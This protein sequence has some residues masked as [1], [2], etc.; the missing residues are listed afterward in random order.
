MRHVRVVRK[1][2]VELASDGRVLDVLREGELFGH[3]SMLSGLTTGFEAR[4]GED[5][6]CYRLPADAVV[7]LL[8]RPSGLRYVARS[9]LLASAAGP[10]GSGCGARPRRPAR[11]PPGSRAPRDLRAGL[12]RARHRASHGGGGGKRRTR[13]TGRWAARHRHRPRPAR[14][15]R[16]R[17]RRERR[18]RQ[19]GDE[20]PGIH[21]DARALRRRRHARDARPRS[22]P[23]ARGLAARRGDGSAHRSRSPGGRSARALLAAANDRGGGR[24]RRAARERD[25]AEP[26][27]DRTPRCRGPARSDRLDHGRGRGRAHPAAD[28]ASRRRPRAFPVR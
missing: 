23:R 20:R 5:M 9:I 10:R 27:G 19:R 21:G 2:S 1:G 3:P 7:P 22:P 24:H 6:L 25:P 16:G 17:G 11:R 15:G 28:R 26:G 8:T 12:E 18:A 4:A 13:A 14:S